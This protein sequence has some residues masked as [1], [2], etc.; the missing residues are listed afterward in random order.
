[1]VEF[2]NKPVLLIKKY[3]PIIHFSV[4]LHALI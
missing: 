1:M 2:E 4:I 3:V